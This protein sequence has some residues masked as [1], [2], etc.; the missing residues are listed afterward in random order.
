MTQRTEIGVGI[1]VDEHRVLV[2]KRADGQTLAGYHEFPGGKRIRAESLAETVR[3]ECR[4]E[5]G[6]AVEVLDLIH[7][8]G[9][10]YSHGRLSLSFYYCRP[11][12]PAAAPRLP[13]RWVPIA[14]LP[15]LQ[16]PPANDEVLRR[17]AELGSEELPA[18]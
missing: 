13:F 18:D 6:L 17:L 14:Q 8:C 5:T 1:V 2:G 15:T 9:H 4:E 16:F 10:D 11:L 3:R 7:I 12:D